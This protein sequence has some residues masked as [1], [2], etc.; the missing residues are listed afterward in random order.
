MNGNSKYMWRNVNTKLVYNPLIKYVWTNLNINSI[1]Y[2]IKHLYLNL[3]LLE[4]PFWIFVS[5]KKTYKFGLVKS[6]LIM[7]ICTLKETYL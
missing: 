1:I 2:T 6:M 5:S 3:L 4:V 7:F